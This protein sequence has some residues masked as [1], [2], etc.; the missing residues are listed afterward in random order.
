M[1]Y[2][3][4]L[5]RLV[6][7][8]PLIMVGSG[9]LSIDSDEQ[10]LMVLRTDNGQWGIPGGALEPGESL[11]EAAHRELA[12][13]T[14]LSAD[15]LRLLTVLSGPEFYY[16]YPNGDEVHNVIALFVA[17]EVSGTARP[18]NIETS[19]V[20]RFS[21]SALPTELD[22]IDKLSIEYFIDHGI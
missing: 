5:R 19:E 22:P 6:G 4:N 3:R 18:C 9:V 17:G 10:L 16:Q 1:G 13:E 2:I 14:G 12:E 20:Q 21:L 7:S 11:E 15:S 8:R